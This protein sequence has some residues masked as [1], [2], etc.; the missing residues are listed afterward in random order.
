MS[1][2]KD[3]NF[4]NFHKEIL[5]DIELSLPCL[6]NSFESYTWA[7]LTKQDYKK[8]KQYEKS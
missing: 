3:C 5:I 2:I 6:A 1:K 7:K 4:S 8:T